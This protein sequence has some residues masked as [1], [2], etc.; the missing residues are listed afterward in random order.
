MVCGASLNGV[1]NDVLRLLVRLLLRL[2]LYFLYHNGGLMSDL[3]FGVGKKYRLGLI[4]RVTGNSLQFF[5]LARNS[6]VQILMF[7]YQRLFFLCNAF[8]FFLD[9]FYLSV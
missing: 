2:G 3:L 6:C 7:V 4:H 5:H 8:F 9:V 1:G